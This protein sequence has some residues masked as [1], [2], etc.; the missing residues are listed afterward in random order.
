MQHKKLLCIAA[1]VL[2]LTTINV[3][4]AILYITRTVTVTGGVA[5]SGTIT[6]YKEDQTTE[7]TALNIPKFK[8][9]IHSSTTVFWIKNTGNAPA[10]V[11]WEISSGTPTWEIDT[12]TGSHS[13]IS[14]EGTETKYRANINKSP[15]QEAWDPDPTGTTS[16][17]TI[18]TGESAKFSIDIAHYTAVNTVGDFNF[19]LSFT[20]ESP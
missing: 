18:N 19:V 16:T 15:S 14:K 8:G 13:Y 9:D 3:A 12:D 17:V 20:S 1:L 11:H 4:I 6:I 5:A 2:T 10:K 7:M